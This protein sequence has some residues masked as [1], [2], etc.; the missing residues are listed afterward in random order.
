MKKIDL[1]SQNRRVRIYDFSKVEYARYIS[2]V[3]SVIISRGNAK[4]LR[5]KRAHL[6]QILKRK[7]AGE[8]IALKEE[9]EEKNHLRLIYFLLAPL[10]LCT[11]PFAACVF[12][13]ITG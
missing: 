9:E 2:A 12:K 6:R 10:F 1:I 13:Q 5:E 11:F 3:A 4:R 7:S 8:K